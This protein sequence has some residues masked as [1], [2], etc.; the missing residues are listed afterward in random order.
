MLATAIVE[1]ENKF[2]Q[3]IPCR[4]LLDSASQLNFISERCIQRLRLSKSQQ[5]T[6]IQGVNNVNT[7]NNHSVSIHLRSR[8][9]DWLICD[10]G[11]QIGSFAIKAFRLAHLQSRHSDWLICDQGIQIGSFAIKVFRLAHHNQLCSVATCNK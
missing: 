1:I 11:I 9:S 10:Q 8:H 6:S 4:V 7:T 5:A 3:Y 2:N